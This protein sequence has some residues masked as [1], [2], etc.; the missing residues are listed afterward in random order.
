[1][2]N[3]AVQA[4]KDPLI[5]KIEYAQGLSMLCYYP[6]EHTCTLAP[7]PRNPR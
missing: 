2:N 3:P 6:L 5:A 7:I 1:M 4:A